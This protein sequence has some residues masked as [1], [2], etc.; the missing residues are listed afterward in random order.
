MHPGG[1][2]KD[3]P[4]G[5]VR[6]M[7]ILDTNPFVDNVLVM[8]VTGAQL[9]LVLEQSFTQLRGLMSVSGIDT[10]YDTSQPEYQR[11]ISVKRNGV[12]VLDNDEFDVAVSGIIAR[13]GDHFDMF[14]DTEFVR[15][16][17]PIAELMIAY[18]RKHGNVPVPANGRQTDIAVVNQT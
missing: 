14:L 8:R 3:L 9:K 13:G 15:E 6:I 11:L 7:D 17:T 4:A 18:Y 10:V 5:D 2:R 1:I 16:L 12:E